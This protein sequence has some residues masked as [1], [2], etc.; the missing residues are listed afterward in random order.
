[1]LKGYL[2]M[3]T[4]FTFAIF[5]GLLLGGQRIR[6]ILLDYIL[7]DYLG[8]PYKLFS[9]TDGQGQLPCKKNIAFLFLFL[10]TQ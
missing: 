8:F 2:I 6:S 10:H 4:P 9:S 5:V 1:M 7:L 3:I